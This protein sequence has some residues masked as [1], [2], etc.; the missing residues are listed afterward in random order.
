LET[1]VH[2]PTYQKIRGSSC[3]PGTLQCVP[4]VSPYFGL[5]GAYSH[6][7]YAADGCGE[8]A[9][10]GRSMVHEMAPRDTYHSDI[11]LTMQAEI[12]VDMTS[13]QLV[14]LSTCGSSFKKLFNAIIW[15]VQLRD[16]VHLPCTTLHCQNLY[17][18]LL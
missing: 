3:Y 9:H 2:P 12:N 4:L 13:V 14:N 1:R 5:I 8:I 16:G 18:F 17:I 6:R 11:R 7:T 15:S 10:V